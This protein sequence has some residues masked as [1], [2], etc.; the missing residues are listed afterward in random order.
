[1]GRYR[2]SKIKGAI[3]DLDGVVV[4]TVPIH[5]RAWKRMFTEYGRKFTFQDYKEKG[6]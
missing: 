2:H 6:E 3:F 1:M 5:F 4:D